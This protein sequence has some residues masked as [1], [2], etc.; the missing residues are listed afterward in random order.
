M[1]S[2]HLQLLKYHKRINTAFW[3]F[4]GKQIQSGVLYNKEDELHLTFYL[5]TRIFFYKKPSKGHNSISFLFQVQILV[6]NV[7]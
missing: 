1:L 5:T 6:L 2:Q 4:S 7:S 3:Y